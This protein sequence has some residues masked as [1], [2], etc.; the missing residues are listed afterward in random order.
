MS[1]R[2]SLDA[3][4]KGTASRSKKMCSGSEASIAFIYVLS[5]EQLGMRGVGGRSEG[6]EHIRFVLH[7]R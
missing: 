3:R 1:C 2:S 4:T 5:D 6:P 7:S